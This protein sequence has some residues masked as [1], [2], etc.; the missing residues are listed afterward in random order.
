MKSNLSD[1]NTII[2]E[3]GINYLADK[4]RKSLYAEPYIMIPNY[5]LLMKVLQTLIRIQKGEFLTIS[6]ERF[7][8]Y[9]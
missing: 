1:L 7:Q 9:Q 2:G 6:K 5:L 8:T 4:N 3:K